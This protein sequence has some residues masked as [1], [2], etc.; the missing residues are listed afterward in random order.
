MRNFKNKSHFWCE[1]NSFLGHK[2]EYLVIVHDSVARLDPLRVNITIKNDPFVELGSLV[3]TIVLV[4]ISH[5]DREDTV[6]PF[7]SLRVHATKKLIGCNGLR[8]NN[9]KDSFLST[10]VE[11]LSSHLPNSCLTATWVTNNEATVTY[12]KNF[13]IVDTLCHKE[14]LSLKTC[15]LRVV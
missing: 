7:L 10:A 2:G 5:D 4:H 3:R 15:F 1:R 12:F 14:I 9:I 13:S 6:F 11:G 8:I